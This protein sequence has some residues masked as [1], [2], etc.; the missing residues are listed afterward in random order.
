M[1][2]RDLLKFHKTRKHLA[3]GYWSSPWRV[4]ENE[5]IP[6]KVRVWLQDKITAR[7]RLAELYLPCDESTPGAVSCTCVKNTTDSADRA[8]VSCHGSKFSPGYLKFLHQTQ[9]WCS[10][11]SSLFSLT[12]VVVST[13]KKANVLVLADDQLTGTIETQDKPYSNANAVNWD[14][15]F[16]AFRRATGETFVLEFSKDS[17]ASWTA[18]SL[19]EVPSPGLGF[20]STIGGASLTGS[21][22]V[23]FRVTMSRLSVDDLTPAFEIVRLRRPLPENSNRNLKR[24]RPDY[25]A[26]QILL[27]RPWT[28]IQDVLEPGRGRLVEHMA[29]RT[30]TVALDFFDWSLDH[31]T[32]ACKIDDTNGPHPFYIFTAGIQGGTRYAINKTYYNDNFGASAG[33]FTHQYF[34]DRRIQPEE[35]TSLVW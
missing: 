8:C 15:K 32:P 17:G 35:A 33:I 11:E 24:Q 29:D 22:V 3:P 2:G 21:G 6:A 18:L 31:D 26:G 34:D 25:V 27:L 20:T 5:Q 7:G 10:A 16:E 9:F 28:Q 19:T 14:L 4:I 12:N 13:T 23:R 1:A 30:W